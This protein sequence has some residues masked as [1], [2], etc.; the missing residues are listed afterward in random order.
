[1]SRI[2]GIKNISEEEKARI[3]FLRHKGLSPAEI[4]STLG[5]SK[6]SVYSVLTRDRAKSHNMPSQ[7][8]GVCEE[9]LAKDQPGTFTRTLQDIFNITRGGEIPDV[10]LPDGHERDILRETLE[11]VMACKA[12]LQRLADVWEA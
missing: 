2:A 8:G 6:Q 12:I 4:S 5:R 3:I 9:R 10:P 1:M 7:S 11:Q